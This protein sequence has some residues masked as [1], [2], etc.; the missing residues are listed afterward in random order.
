MPN[1]PM[2]KPASRPKKR[3]SL[4]EQTTKVKIGRKGK[5]RGFPRGKSIA[6]RVQAYFSG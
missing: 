2:S 5:V 4:A 1:V 3:K 6:Y